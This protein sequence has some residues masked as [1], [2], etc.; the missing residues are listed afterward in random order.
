[1]QVEGQTEVDARA[2][3]A[4]AGLTPDVKYQDVPQ[5]DVNIGKVISQGTD[6]ET[7]VDPG[8]IIRLTIGR[9]AA[10]TP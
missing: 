4:T 8:F 6:A 10:V 2:L 5:N 1:P 7:M 3:L 9:A